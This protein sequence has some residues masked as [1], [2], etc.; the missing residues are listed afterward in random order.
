MFSAFMDDS[1]DIAATLATTQACAVEGFA[2]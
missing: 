2:Q 1:S